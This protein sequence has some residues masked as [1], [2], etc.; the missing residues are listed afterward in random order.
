MAGLL[1]GLA[2]AKT[3]FD[4][5]RTALGA[6]KDAKELLPTDQKEAVAATIEASERQFALAEAEIAKGLGYDL[7]KC[8]FPPT[9]MLRAGYMRDGTIV[10]ECPTCKNNTMPGRLFTR[11]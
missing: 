5:L 3:G 1:E 8:Q 7:C 10:Y 4:L 2:A 6:V 9:I 11:D